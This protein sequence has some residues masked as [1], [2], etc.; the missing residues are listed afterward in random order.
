MV[1]TSAN[2]RPTRSATTISASPTCETLMCAAILATHLP[3]PAIPL[4]ETEPLLERAHAVAGHRELGA[5]RILQP[6]GEPAAEVRVQLGD[7]RHVQ[8]RTAMDAQETA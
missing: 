8:Q 4:E 1:G 6:H 2:T 5:P 7:V 3:P